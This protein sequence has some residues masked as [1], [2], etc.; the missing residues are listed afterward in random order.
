MANLKIGKPKRMDDG[1]Q[2]VSLRGDMDSKGALSLEGLMNELLDR[3]FYNVILDFK[4]VDFVSSA[5]VGMLLGLV[6]SLRRKDGEAYFA[7]VSLKIMAVFE[8][9]NLH[10]YFKFELPRRA[11]SKV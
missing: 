11:E 7:N 3:E 10:E 6:S 4:D 5:G 1:N 8:L 2:Y 9:L